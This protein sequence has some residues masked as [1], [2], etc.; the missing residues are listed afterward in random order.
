MFLGALALLIIIVLNSNTDFYFLIPFFAMIILM[1]SCVSLFL[2]AMLW[3][4]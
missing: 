2:Y 4:E 3:E 1:N